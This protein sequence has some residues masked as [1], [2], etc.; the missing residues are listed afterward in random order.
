M[1]SVPAVRTDHGLVP[2]GRVAKL[3]VRDQ[4]NMFERED[5]QR[6]VSIDFN[7]DTRDLQTWVDCARAGLKAAPE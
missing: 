7:L 2:L 4:V 5:G 6:C 1:W 3:H